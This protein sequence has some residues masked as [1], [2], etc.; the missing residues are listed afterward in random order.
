MYS[1]LLKRICL[2]SASTKVC[3]PLPCTIS[4]K[5]NSKSHARLKSVPL[6]VYKELGLDYKSNSSICMQLADQSLIQPIG[7]VEDLLIKVGDLVF[8]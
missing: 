3:S 6:K 4:N 5:E 8:C 2:G 7:M 1:H